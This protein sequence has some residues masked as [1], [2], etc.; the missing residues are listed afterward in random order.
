[1]TNFHESLKTMRIGIVFALLTLIFGFGL[2]GLFG[3]IEDELKGYLNNKAD[4]V[5]DTVYNKDEVLHKKI[6]SKSWVYF[7]RAHLHANGLG[8]TS[9]VLIMLLTG[10][11]TKKLLKSWTAG[12]LGIGSLGYSVFWL[13]AG[14]RSPGLGSTSLAK[15]SLKFLALPTAGMCILG[16]LIVF[17]IALTN[18]MQ[19]QKK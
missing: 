1:M 14:M 9:L 17:L 19:D 8:T 3:A 11:N 2:G 12:F 18:F 13:L 7:K 10:I 5:F 16:V 6:T 15:E 4:A